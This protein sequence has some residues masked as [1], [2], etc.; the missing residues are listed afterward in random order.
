MPTLWQDQGG[1]ASCYLH[2]KPGLSG[3]SRAAGV[4]S[5]GKSRWGCLGVCLTLILGVEGR[6]IITRG[7][8]GIPTPKAGGEAQA[9]SASS[10]ATEAV[11]KDTVRNPE[12][13]SP[14]STPAL[15]EISAKPGGQGGVSHRS[16]CEPGSAWLHTRVRH[17]R[18]RCR[19]ALAEKGL[20]CSLGVALRY[21]PGTSEWPQSSSVH[22]P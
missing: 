1:T 18:T 13:S 15:S 4:D 7:W 21:I 17:W 8:R 5:A 6:D 3:G 19:R 2:G 16:R 22:L 14:L 10:R 11:E 12:V 20:F 9:N